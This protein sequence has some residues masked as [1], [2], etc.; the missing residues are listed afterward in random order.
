VTDPIEPSRDPY[1]IASLRKG[2]EVID[3]FSQR[4]SW[5]LTELAGHLAMNKATAFRML[6]TLLDAGFVDRDEESGRYRLGMRFYSLGKT[7]VRHEQLKWQALPPLMTLAEQTG[8]TVYVGILYEGDA[9]VVQVVDGIELVRMHAFVGKRS[10][11][12]A[13]ALGKVLLA[14]LPDA[15]VEAYAET[16]GLKAFTPNTFTDLAAFREELR[17]IRD[18][19][20]ALDREEMAP[21]LRCIGVPVT[22]HTGRPFATVSLSAPV[23]RMGP[24]RIATLIPQV[25][26]A[27]AEISRMLGS[28]SP[29]RRHAA[30]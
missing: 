20:H 13:S 15:E 22:D 6:H 21:G 18:D 12:H 8:E 5:S 4:E 26:T 7:A 14:H 23:D 19:G 29:I 30:G 27:A 28:P 17:R 9:V 11:A 16:Y 25:K 10:P 1:L 24:E 3:C 2:L